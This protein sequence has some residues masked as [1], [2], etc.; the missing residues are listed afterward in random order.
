MFRIQD[1]MKT[2]GQNIT[3]FVKIPALTCARL[4]LNMKNKIK[5]DLSYN[6]TQTEAESLVE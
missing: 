2:K 1:F 6:K 5:Q 3:A 4:Q